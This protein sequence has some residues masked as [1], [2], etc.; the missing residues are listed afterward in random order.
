MYVYIKEKGRN[1]KNKKKRD[2]EDARV[3]RYSLVLKEKTLSRSRVR[4]SCLRNLNNPKRHATFVYG[5]IQGGG[6]RNL[7]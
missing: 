2:K 5:N 3:E 7:T 4:S 1:A 6:G